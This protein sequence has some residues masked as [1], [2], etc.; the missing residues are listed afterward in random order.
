[1]KRGLSP[2]LSPHVELA[3]FSE[4]AEWIDGRLEGYLMT[5]IPVDRFYTTSRVIEHALQGWNNSVE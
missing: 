4:N 1:M 3:M 2:R 5:A